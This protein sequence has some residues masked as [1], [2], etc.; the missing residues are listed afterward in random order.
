MD[1]LTFEFTDLQKQDIMEQ[2]N[3]S[4]DVNKMSYKTLNILKTLMANHSVLDNIE[5][6]T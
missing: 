2:M 6:A 3:K 5:T 4:L 1:N